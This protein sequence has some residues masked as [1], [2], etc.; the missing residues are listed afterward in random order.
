MTKLSIWT[1]NNIDRKEIKEVIKSWNKEN[2]RNL[3]FKILDNW[4]NVN[5]VMNLMEELL[6]DIE[7]YFFKIFKEEVI[8]KAKTNYYWAIYVLPELIKTWKIDKE[9]LNRFFK[10][11]VIKEAKTND[12]WARYVLPELIKTWKIDEEELNRFFK[13]EAIEKA[14]T[15][16]YWARSVLPE[17]IKTWKIDEEGI[18]L[19][20]RFFKEEVIKK[21]ETNDDWAKSVLPA[22][23]ETW[24]IDKNILD[25]V[26]KLALKKNWVEVI[27]SCI[28][29]WYFSWVKESYSEK[30]NEYKKIAD[31]VF[32]LLD[33]KIDIIFLKENILNVELLNVELLNKIKNFLN[34]Y[35]KIDK[36]F[37]IENLEKILKEKSLEYWYFRQLVLNEKQLPEDIEEFPI[38][39]NNFTD[40]MED[41]EVLLE[42]EQ[43]KNTKFEWIRPWSKEWFLENPERKKYLKPEYIKTFKKFGT[44]IWLWII[45]WS[46][47]AKWLSKYYTEIFKN[48]SQ[49]KSRST[50]LQLSEIFNLI[51]KKENYNI[52]DEI[53]EWQE[54]WKEFKEF[55]EENKISEK[56][57]TI[58]TLLIARE[59][60]DSFQVWKKDWEQQVDTTRLDKLILQ[61]SKKLKKYKKVIDKYKEVSIKTSIW[62][63]IEITESIAKAYKEEVWSDYKQDIMILSEYAW[64]AEWNDA[65]HEIATKPTD[66][67]YLLLLELQLLQDL[68][69]LDLNFKK[70]W[71][72]K[73]ARW[74]HITL[75]WENWIELNKDTNF[76]QNILIASN[77][78]WL[79]AWDEIKRVNW[80]T[81][82]REKWN[83]CEVLFWERTECLEYRSLS[84]DKMEQFE[85]LIISIYNLNMSYQVYKENTESE[86]GRKFKKLK[87]D[88][89]EIIQEHNKNF[90][91]NEIWWEEIDEE[92]LRL[93]NTKD[94]YKNLVKKIWDKKK[95]ERQK[96]ILEWYEKI[97]RESKKENISSLDKLDYEDEKRKLTN[98]KR[99]E[100]VIWEDKRYLESI[101]INPEEFFE[102]ITA[103][104]INK[105]TK[106]NNLF[107]KKDSTNALAMYST[108]R[109]KYWLNDNEKL[110][111][112]SVFDLLDRNLEWRKWA[113]IIQWASEK[114]ITYAIQK[115]ILEFNEKIEEKKGNEKK[116]QNR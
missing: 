58:L 9:E 45:E 35:E 52:F 31:E 96:K 26:F 69:F 94:K 27:K 100:E 18:K 34:R 51:L 99:F 115:R 116:L 8:E 33:K 10:E 4:W 86:L 109:E 38:T 41:W 2:F 50:I 105:F 21:A 37:F 25:K 106:I 56:W 76:I 97:M 64:I 71:Y 40:F 17:L 101:K 42:F 54:I 62:V 73:W 89:I 43:D 68:D 44:I 46:E 24:K 13:E 59:I 6:P 81:N 92:L 103:E 70:E 113:Y 36:D 112:Y 88:I 83:D 107:I 104:S 29:Q 80:Y 95:T 30:F 22:L 82:I 14:K 114:M 77:L 102:I 67:P 19:L 15:N 39:I 74:L 90:V 110:S 11:E 57:R 20:N 47:S 91:R 108:T 60:R 85:R 49:E 63:E 65:V 61:I 48:I 111:E 12:Y 7:K 98:R 78:W 23:I 53:V 75:W 16:D 55:I 79:N 1:L 72:N 32:E 3:L 28:E 84:I 87:E 66:N 5:E 93:V